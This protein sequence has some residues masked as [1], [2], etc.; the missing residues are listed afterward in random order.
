MLERREGGG[1]PDLIPPHDVLG[2]VH[3]IS[4]TPNTVVR[5]GSLSRLAGLAALM[6]LLCVSFGFLWAAVSTVGVI[7]AVRRRRVA[8][9][10]GRPLVDEE[11]DEDDVWL[12]GMATPASPVVGPQASDSPGLT[13][14]PLVRLY[15]PTCLFVSL[16]AWLC[17]VLSLCG[18]L[19][20]DC[21]RL[22]G[23]VSLVL[24]PPPHL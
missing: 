13:P 10:S 20:C 15:V 23:S 17:V 24:L 2:C 11:A 21:V 4:P 7:L 12:T 14:P 3:H 5:V 16:R 18:N 19:C 9:A 22:C 1:C 6:L 8:K